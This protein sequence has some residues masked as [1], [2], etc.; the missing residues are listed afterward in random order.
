MSTAPDQPPRL[1]GPSRWVLKVLGVLLLSLA[2]VGAFLPILPTTPFLL[3]AVACFAR[4]SPTLL[5]VVMENRIFGPYITQW[6]R[7]R[8]IPRSAKRKA[9]GLVVLSFGLSISLLDRTDL[10][11]ALLVVGLLLLAF[12]ARLPVSEKESG[13][14]Q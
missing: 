8:S 6:Q 14:G 7:D 2:T 9:Y 5:R 10:R 3:L 12:L 11:M 1:S 13:E 4:S